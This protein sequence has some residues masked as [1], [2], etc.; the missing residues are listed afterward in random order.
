MKLVRYQLF[1]TDA[2]LQLFFNDGKE[3]W[4][5]LDE[6]SGKIVQRLK[7]GTLTDV[8]HPSVWLGTDYNTGEIY[9]LH[10][11]YRQGSAYIATFSDYASGQQVSW[12]QGKTLNNPRVIIQKALDLIIS[13]RRYDKVNYNCQT[14]VNIACN[15]KVA[16][17]DVNKWVGITATFFVVGIALSAL[18]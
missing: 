4:V 13:G 15:N 7:V 6:R 18:K 11:H 14:F 1:P 9:I 3:I 8:I 12:K 10:N 16:S 5:R 17:E 2:L